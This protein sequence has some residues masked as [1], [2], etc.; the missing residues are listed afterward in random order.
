MLTL[1][2]NLIAA[3]RKQRPEVRYRLDIETSTGVWV[4]FRDG[5]G[6]GS[7]HESVMSVS[8]VARASDPVTRELSC[9]Q[10][11]V[12]LALDPLVR[13]LMFSYGLAG[14]T[15]KVWMGEASVSESDWAPYFCGEITD[16]RQ[17]A[18]TLSLTIKAGASLF[19]NAKTKSLA[20]V[21]Y[22]PLEVIAAAMGQDLARYGLE[23]DPFDPAAFADIS[24]WNISRAGIKEGFTYRGIVDGNIE[25]VISAL[26]GMLQGSVQ[27]GTVPGA[28]FKRFDPTT[29][30]DHLV[31]G[32]D[33]I[34]GSFRVLSLYGQFANQIAVRTRSCVSDMVKSPG[35]HSIASAGAF[36]E[37]YTLDD[38]AAQ[39]RYNN[40][41]KALVLDGDFLSASGLLGSSITAV[42]PAAGGTFNVVAGETFSFCGAR[43]PRYGNPTYGPPAQPADAMLSDTRTA[44]LK[45][46]RRNPDGSGLQSEV[47]EVDRGTP[48]G[49]TVLA[50]SEAGLYN[51][52]MIVDPV[53][54]GTEYSQ[55]RVPFGVEFR[56]KARGALGT[57]PLAFV[58]EE[59][60]E[61]TEVTDITIAVAW[62]RSLLPRLANGLFM[63]EFRTTLAEYAQEI[64]DCITV[65]V[66][67]F[68]TQGIDGL[69]DSTV[70][71]IIGKETSKS[72]IKLTVA[73]ADQDTPPAATEAH[74][75]GTFTVPS[76]RAQAE[77]SV[78]NQDIGQSYVVTGFDYSVSGRDIT[79][80]P[81]TASTMLGRGKMHAAFTQTLPVNSDCWAVWDPLAGPALV[82]LTV[83]Y[84]DPA[85]TIP[86]YMCP[87]WYVSTGE[88]SVS[89]HTDLRVWQAI[90]GDRLEAGTGPLSHLEQTTGIIDNLTSVG[91]TSAQRKLDDVGDGSTYIRIAGVSAGHQAQA[92]SIATGAVEEAKIKADAVTAG[93]VKDGAI[94]EGKLGAGAVTAGKIGAQAVGAAAVADGAISTVHTAVG[95]ARH[96]DNGNAYV[97]QRTRG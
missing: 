19:A 16:P 25:D 37:R 29:V 27:L 56:V 87:L 94:T 84:G 67:N 90:P 36:A 2:A 95:D 14:F 50:L 71:E 51:A 39:T 46:T 72:G 28:T 30:V 21:A 83:D 85:P 55:L 91:A 78:Q 65:D 76:P 86:N 73:R 3:W 62:A 4:Y 57:T 75:V 18:G 15:A 13:N 68:V 1:S 81:G 11:T 20:F 5:K 45:L 79:I 31:E 82:W 74:H 26:C 93:K 64:G 80:G 60:G 96:W 63:A 77:E 33:I 58:G 35:P 59:F 12:V 41:I 88:S 6:V 8:P 97:A 7:E 23:D 24:H 92:A 48:W 47:I 9:S 17:E 44:Y 89:A 43:W 42:S 32:V 49:T 38:T 69:D 54:F 52:G 10:V 53:D 61:H 22:H 70:L 40:R 34:E 66:A